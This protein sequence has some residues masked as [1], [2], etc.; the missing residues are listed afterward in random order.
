MNEDEARNTATTT[1]D[2]VMA[3]AP[4]QQ[5]M[6][7]RGQGTWPLFY[8]QPELLDAQAHASW[9]VKPAGVEFAAA[10]NSVPV[11]LGEFS[12]A[13]RHYPLV[14]A[15]PE[16]MP[17][18]VL[19]LGHR[20]LFVKDGTWRADTYVP[21]YVRRYPFVFAEVGSPGQH[22]LAIDAQA[23][24]LARQGDEGTLLF[25]E[26]TPSELT[27]QALRFCDAFTR[28]SAATREFVALL[29]REKLLVE[30]TANIRLPDGG[31]STL[32]GFAVVSAEAFSMLPEALVIEWHRSKRLEQVHAHL[33][34]LARFPDLMEG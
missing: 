15:G 28:E 26:G 16:R 8:R 13:A 4:D 6:H 12:A 22:A 9:R 7:E 34:S 18:A 23:P 20:N 19:G 33:L 11:M 29:E 30:R 17:V 10:V 5:D 24:M 3:E 1:D 27:R 32:G 25:E 14:F 31:L 2:V 21:A